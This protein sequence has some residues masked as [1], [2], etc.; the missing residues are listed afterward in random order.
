[1]G[2]NCIHCHLALLADNVNLMGFPLLKE[3]RE[4][5]L[6]DVMLALLFEED[7]V[8]V[9]L[10]PVWFFDIGRRDPSLGQSS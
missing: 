1:M 4:E 6:C 3:A 9:V 7:R 2:D 5:E 8:S 10:L